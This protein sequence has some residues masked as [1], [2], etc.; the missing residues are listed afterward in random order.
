MG[1]WMS[2]AYKLLSTDVESV[3]PVPNA[4]HHFQSVL[5]F[6]LSLM[7]FH[8]SSCSC[9]QCCCVSTS[10]LLCGHFHGQKQVAPSF[11]WGPYSKWRCRQ[12]LHSETKHKLSIVASTVGSLF[13][14]EA[15][16]WWAS[17]LSLTFGFWN[18]IVPFF[19]I[20]ACLY[21]ASCRHCLYIFGEVFWMHRIQ[22]GERKA[23][24]TET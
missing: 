20:E 16:S 13:F 17:S 24:V 15:K 19:I 23:L 4:Q 18:M 21:N 6:L 12:V 9:L 14:L 7:H 8:V 10:V 11:T 1:L 2:G 3:F 22:Y 5:R